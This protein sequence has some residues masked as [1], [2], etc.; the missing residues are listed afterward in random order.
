MNDLD[1]LS[2]M[3]TKTDT[4]Y[5][6]NYSHDGTYLEVISSIYEGD[7]MLFTFTVDGDLVQVE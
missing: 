1:N 7:S 2:D 3:L 4:H 6:I 5:E